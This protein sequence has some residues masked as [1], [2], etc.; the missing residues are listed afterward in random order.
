MR[1]EPLDDFLAGHLAVLAAVSLHGGVTAAA[2]ALNLTQP[3]VSNRLRTLEG[4]VGGKLVRRAG[5]GI[6]LTELGQ[7]LLPHAESIVRSTARARRAAQAPHARPQVRVAI[8]EAAVPLVMPA[9]AACAGDEPKL[10][11]TTLSCGSAEAVRAVVNGDVDLA[12]V[13]D[14]PD[15]PV[16]DFQHRVLMVD[17]IVLVS[18]GDQPHSL[19][20]ETVSELTILWQSAG[21]SVRSTV[22]RALETAGLGPAESIELGSSLGALAAAAAGHGAAFLPRSYAAAWV[23][24][25]RV[26]VSR[27]RASDLLARFAIVSE[28]SEHLSSGAQRVYDQLLAPARVAT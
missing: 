24:A 28:P 8:S 3:A 26:T 21:S 7:A 2:E 25:G 20:L 4:I 5:R 18:A 12:V 23:E 13:I 15:R 27:L 11:L 16:D 6:E 9:L 22:E 10:R 17:E 14:A 1:E 19:A